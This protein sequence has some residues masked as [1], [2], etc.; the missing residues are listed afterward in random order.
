MLSTAISLFPFAL[1][2]DQGVKAYKV[3]RFSASLVVR[4]EVIP[5]TSPLYKTVEKTLP[6]YH[7]KEKHKAFLRR[8]NIRDDLL[9]VEQKNDQ[10]CAAFG[11]NYFT[12]GDAA[13]VMYPKFSEVDEEASGF[14]FKHEACHI[15]HNDQFKLP[16]ITAV[17][18]FAA[19]FF[20]LSTKQSGKTSL[21]ITL[22]VQSLV[23]VLGS[24]Y[25]ERRADN[26]AIANASDQELRGGKRHFLSG[27][28]A[29][30]EMRTSTWKKL[31]FS[32]AGE[33]RLDINHPSFQSRIKKIEKELSRRAVEDTVTAG[34]PLV[35]RL[36]AL[37]ND[38]HSS[39]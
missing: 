12:Q 4:D 13:I 14:T 15:K 36:K 2:L 5:K 22:S 11:T 6:G 31:I 23:Y 30:K 34:D 21:M 39:F 10:F 28:E 38:L 1:P 25:C 35:I 27:Q 17:F 16:A 8:E 26:F 20:C 32:P 37:A 24:Q 19:A 3:S 29:N 33:F 18:S 7:Y 9:V